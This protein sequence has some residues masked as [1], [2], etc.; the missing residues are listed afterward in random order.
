[1]VI[2]EI[3]DRPKA[4]QAAIWELRTGYLRAVHFNVS[5]TEGD[6]GKTA[7]V[8]ALGM[9]RLKVVYVDLALYPGT[10]RGAL[11]RSY[12]TLLGHR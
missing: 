12:R 4:R 9:E 2:R 3:A 5:N 7:V 8:N 6:S 11:Y 1:M 10:Q